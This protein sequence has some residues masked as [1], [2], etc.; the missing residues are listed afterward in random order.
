[1]DSKVKVITVITLVALLMIGCAKKEA[2]EVVIYTSLDQIFSEP[3]LKAF[4]KKTGIK[5]KAVYDVEAAKTTGLVNRLIAEKNNPQADVF[6]N[7]E[8]G[9][10]LILKKMGILQPYCSSSAENIPTQF[11]DP[12]GYWTGFAAR[13]RVIIINTDLIKP[14]EQPES[15]FE[16]VKEDYKGEV[17]VANPLFGTTST[18]SAALFVKLGDEEA[19]Q[20]FRDLRANDVAIVDGNS[21]VRDLVAAGE[22]KMGLTDT[23]DANL[24][25]LEGRP[26]KI[27]YPDQDTL[28]TL[29]IPNTVALIKDAPHPQEARELI[30]YLLSEEVEERLAHSGSMQMPVR[31]TV[32]T[33]DYVPAIGKVKAM[34][35]SY[36][37]IAKQKEETARILQEIFLR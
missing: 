33:P 12:Q 9:R 23:D 26:V 27:I 13:A 2:K 6:W 17:A 35:V 1:M 4:E 20:Y 24:A 5:V 3:V 25:L 21:V 16:L 37:Q 28:G 8:V 31:A 18:H 32:N 29:V 15:I 19:R 30:D 11:K 7:S 22:L 10:T 36:E 14:D 34:E